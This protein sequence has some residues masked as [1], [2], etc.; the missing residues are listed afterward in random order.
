[1]TRSLAPVKIPQTLGWLRRSL[2]SPEY[3]AEQNQRFCFFSGKEE[4]HVT[5]SFTRPRGSALRR[6]LVNCATGVGSLIHGSVRRRNQ[7]SRRQH[8]PFSLLFPSFP[9]SAKRTQGVLGQCPQKWLVQNIGIFEVA[10]T[11]VIGL[12]VEG[13]GRRATSGPQ[14]CLV[15]ASVYKRGYRFLCFCPQKLKRK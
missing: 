1:V 12:G 3:S 4:N 14:G 6:A 8:T 10:I 7:Y 5:R 13:S 9:I 15:S 11:D 2:V